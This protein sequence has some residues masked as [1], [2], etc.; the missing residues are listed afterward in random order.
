M[1]LSGMDEGYYL[2]SGNEFN[3]ITSDG[4]DLFDISVG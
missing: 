2:D 3:K 1:G 4:T